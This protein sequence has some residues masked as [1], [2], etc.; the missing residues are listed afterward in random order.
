MQWNPAGTALAITNVFQGKKQLTLLNAQGNSFIKLPFGDTVGYATDMGAWRSDDRLP[1]M[2]GNKVFIFNLIKQYMQTI[3]EHETPVI[4]VAN[5]HNA[6]HLVTACKGLLK[7][8]NE[9]YKLIKKL[10]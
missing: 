2:C 6:Q 3:L 9:Q 1:L 10:R 7:V 4:D 5:S 8:W